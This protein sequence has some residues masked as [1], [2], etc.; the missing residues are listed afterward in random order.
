MM[1]FIDG[2]NL[3]ARYQGMLKDGRTPLPEVRHRKDVYTWSQGAVWPGMSVVLR[4][5]YYT[6]AVGSD[7]V[8]LEAA[9]E[10]RTLTFAQYNPPGHHLSPRLG[11]ALYPKVLKKIKD[12][13]NPKGV[14]IQLTVDVLSNT[15]QNNLDVVYLV[16]GDGDYAPLIAECQRQGK[17]VF[18]AALSSGLNPS[19]KVI[20][21][22]F[23]DLDNYFVSPLGS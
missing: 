17:Q 20:A 2:E 4:A 11:D 22:R 5:T 23:I 13:R 1:V 21:D 9:N 14:D 8:I 18:V 3:V 19:L 15:Y 6:Y 10:I 12:A 7:E 16:A